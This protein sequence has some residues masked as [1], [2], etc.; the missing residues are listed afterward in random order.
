MAG[1]SALE[2]ITIGLLLLSPL[3]LPLGVLLCK[4][5]CRIACPRVTVRDLPA[6][7]VLLGAAGLLALL[8]PLGVLLAYVQP[9]LSL[10]ILGGLVIVVVWTRIWITLPRS[11]PA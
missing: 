10:S 11:F 6:I 4:R 1:S 3:L 5:R 2:M 7:A 9:T 8:L